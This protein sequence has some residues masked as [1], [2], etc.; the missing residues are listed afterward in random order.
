MGNF[1]YFRLYICPAP[2][3]TMASHIAR[4]GSGFQL[5]QSLFVFLRFICFSMRVRAME[6]SC[7]SS[8]VLSSVAVC[9]AHELQGI[10]QCSVM[11]NDRKYFFT[12]YI[13]YKVIVRWRI[14]A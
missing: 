6:S 7:D 13:I 10:M 1:Q 9:C 3:I 14:T 5:L 8:L 2:G 4:F 12:L 11:N